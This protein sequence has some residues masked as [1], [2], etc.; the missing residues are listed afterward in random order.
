MSEAYLRTEA[1][2]HIG[3][4]VKQEI[5]SYYNIC[6]QNVSGIHFK[7][8]EKVFFKMES[9]HVSDHTEYRMF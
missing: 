9:P 1:F 6:I 2:S 7:N 5:K 8:V 3:F 4:E